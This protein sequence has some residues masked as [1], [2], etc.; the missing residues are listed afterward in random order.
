MGDAELLLACLQYSPDEGSFRWRDGSGRKGKPGQLAGS[1]G[2]SGYARIRYGSR[3]YLSHR[4]AILALTGAWPE[5]EVDHINGS[6]A[7]NRAC[8]LRVVTREQN[9]QNL[10]AARSDNRSGYL[11][12]SRAGS[13]WQARIDVSGVQKYLGTFASPEEAHGAYVSAK[14]LL[15]PTCSI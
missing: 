14:R 15:H 13:R 12:V 3:Q 4:L 1:I 6:K 7:D 9:Q 8:N 2:K 11:G 10:R 5:G